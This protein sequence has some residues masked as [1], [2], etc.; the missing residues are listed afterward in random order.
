MAIMPFEGGPAIKHFEISVAKWG[1]DASTLQYV[2]THNGIDNIWEQPVAGGPPRQVTHFDTGQMFSWRFSRDRKQLA[3]S[4]G[5]M[6][7]DVV[8]ISNLK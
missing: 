2:S 8:M 4:R 1:A 6:P 3:M 7:Q 5:R